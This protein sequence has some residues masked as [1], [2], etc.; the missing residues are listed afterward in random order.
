MRKARSWFTGAVGGR[1]TSC[2]KNV[3]MTEEGESLNAMGDV[4]TRTRSSIKKDKGEFLYFN[5]M[6]VYARVRACVR[7]HQQPSYKNAVVL[8]CVDQR[9]LVCTFQIGN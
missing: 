2:R 5:V 9:A 1:K 7:V 6:S 4:R 8:I 3:H